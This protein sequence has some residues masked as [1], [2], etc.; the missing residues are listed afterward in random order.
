MTTV[1]LTQGFHELGDEAE[2]IPYLS[3]L[4]ALA[5]HIPCALGEV[6]TSE[7]LS[8]VHAQLLGEVSQEWSTALRAISLKYSM[9]GRI[10]AAEGHLTIDRAGSGLPTW[11][12]MVK[13]SVDQKN[14]GRNL[15]SLP[16]SAALREA[17]L[18]VML[19]G[20]VFPAREQ[21]ALSQ[22]LYLEVLHGNT[23]S[24]PKS[25]M[26]VYS[27]DTPFNGRFRHVAGWHMIDVQTGSAVLFFLNL[28]SE[29]DRKLSRQDARA[30]RLK[31]VMLGHS[32]E[33]VSLADLAKSSAAVSAT[34][35][36][37][38]VRRL[39][40]G[41]FLSPTLS[42]G[43]DPILRLMRYHLAGSQEDWALKICTD[44]LCS[45]GETRSK[46][47]FKTTIRQEFPA[48]PIRSLGY[49]MTPLVYQALCEFGGAEFRGVRKYVVTA[50][51]KVTAFY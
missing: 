18:R 8:P 10:K 25:P 28:E 39:T 29:T 20:Q 17:M 22:R 9:S 23:M 31:S 43:D 14:A 36:P 37:R 50:P 45:Q 42:V 1:D 35:Q 26:T 38:A 12:E 33:G 51:G 40:L 30:R 27:A 46:G 21:H 34:L 16:S 15:E 5:A 32:H 44:T 4:Q 19:Q 47:I 6:A 41:P 24:F 13:L 3:R 48:E 49:L 7:G 11:Q 2:L